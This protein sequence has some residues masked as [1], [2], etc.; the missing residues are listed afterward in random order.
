MRIDTTL[1]GLALTALAAPA[2][3]TGTPASKPA[4]A[5]KEAKYCV[6]YE[7]STGSRLRDTDCL[8]KSEWAK[9]GVDVDKLARK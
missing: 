2:I 4:S 1:L 3:A 7:K 5:A 6:E 8:T 9:R